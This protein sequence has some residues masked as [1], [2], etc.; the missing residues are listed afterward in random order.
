MS[1]EDLNENERRR[2]ETAEQSKRD[3]RASIQR[4]QDKL[5]NLDNKRETLERA[6]I[7][8]TEAI[9]RIEHAEA[10]AKAS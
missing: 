3:L 7:S 5:A 4:C 6:I 2:L 1:I 8:K 9:R 10:I